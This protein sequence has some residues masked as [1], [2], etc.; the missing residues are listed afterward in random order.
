[1]SLLKPLVAPEALAVN[2][3]IADFREQCV[4]LIGMV[5]E[6]RS[7]VSAAFVP[8][9]EQLSRRLPAKKRIKG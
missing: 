5:D 2:K 1:M 6:V 3:E 9:S 7:H 4:A 8:Y